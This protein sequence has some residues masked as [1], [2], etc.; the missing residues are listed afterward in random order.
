MAPTTSY[1]VIG[2]NSGTT[3]Y[4]RVRASTFEVDYGDVLRLCQ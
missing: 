2:L 3:Y 1:V 4:Y